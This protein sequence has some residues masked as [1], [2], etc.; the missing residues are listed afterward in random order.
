MSAF[1]SAGKR[2]P[3]GKR[4][5]NGRIASAWIRMVSVE[6]AAAAPLSLSLSLLRLF[7]DRLMSKEFDIIG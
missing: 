6:V 5:Q 1:V 2:L 4:P 3:F 7:S